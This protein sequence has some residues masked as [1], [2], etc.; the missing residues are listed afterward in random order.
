MTKY[1]RK[2][3]GDFND[4][5]FPLKNLV[6]GADPKSIL[7]SFFAGV[8]TYQISIN[9]RA[10]PISSDSPH[11]CAEMKQDTSISFGFFALTLEAASK[12]RRAIA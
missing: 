10:K 9:Q 11:L 12:L 6:R 1:K 7:R 4:R 8:S 3:S 2:L 5:L